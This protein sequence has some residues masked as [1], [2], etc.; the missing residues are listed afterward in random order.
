MKETL[1]ITE[2][3]S[4]AK[5]VAEALADKKPTKQSTWG[6]A[7]YTLTH[8]K[9]P[10]IV[11]CAVGHLYN[12]KEV[13]KNGWTYPVYDL[14]WFPSYEIRKDAEYTKPY[15]T[16]IENLSKKDQNIVVACDYDIEGSTIGW[17]VVKFICHKKDGRRM[18]FSTLT[19]DELIESYEKASKHLDFPQITAGETRHYLDFIWGIN[20]SRALTLSIKNAAN[21]FKVMSIGR[22]Q[23]PTLKIIVDKEKEIQKFTPE[24]FW[25]I[26]LDGI[27]NKAKIKAQHEKIKFKDKKAANKVIIK[28]KG[29]KA[30]VKSIKKSTQN[31]QPPFPFDLTTLQTEAYRTLGMQPK[32][33]LVHAQSLYSSGYI[34]YPR[35]SSQKLP[36]QLGLKKILGKLAK[37]TPYLKLVNQLLEKPNLKPN[38][39]KKTDAAHPAIHPTGEVPKRLTGRKASV[40]DLV[41]RRF[42]AT[43]AEHA[44]RE[45]VTL[46]IDVN[47]EIFIAKGTRTV[48]PGW[49]TYYGRFA[50]FKE[51]ELPKTQ[52]GDEVKVKKI[53]LDEKETQPPKRYTPASII[54]QME[55]LNIG[56][57]STRAAIV[58][59]LAERNYISGTSLEATGLGIKTIDTLK[60]YCPDIIDVKLTKDIELDLEKIQLGKKKEDTIL[61]EAKTILN[62]IVKEFKQNELKIGKA[63]SEANKETRYQESILGQCPKCKKGQFRTL[64]SR[65]V[66]KYFA[67]CNGYP[68]CKTTSSFPKEGKVIPTEKLC[69]ECKYPVI[70]VARPG[71]RMYEMCLNYSCASKESWGKKDDKAVKKKTN[72]QVTKKMSKKIASKESKSK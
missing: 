65:R 40:Y 21:Q 56:T 17:N 18:K 54:K 24:K 50:K 20:L 14:D 34:S 31:Q 15:I 55:S 11:V 22:V 67:A 30:F 26:Y 68:K 12:L 71:K 58:D 1:I 37:Q 28:T 44:K 8:N 32:E 35:T 72:K 25:E 19:K 49:H 16:T 39:G 43:F 59:A 60:K 6:V 51:E 63:L 53:T 23:G 7:Y 27:L 38:E 66:K 47:K 3:P 70:R 62:K 61:K 13:K 46:N 29:K 45:T 36:Q 52:E 2:K 10:I 69:K 33:T 9:Q 48:E 57:K 64:Y 5:K 41:V 42:L 4:Q